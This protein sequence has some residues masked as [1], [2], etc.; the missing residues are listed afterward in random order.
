MRIDSAGEKT[1]LVSAGRVMPRPGN[2]RSQRA[3][4]NST[5][6]STVKTRTAWS[7]TTLLSPQFQ[8]CWSA[9]SWSVTRLILSFNTCCSLAGISTQK[10]PAKPAIEQ[11]SIGCGVSLLRTLSPDRNRQIHFLVRCGGFGFGF[12]LL[13]L[14]LDSGGWD[15]L[16]GLGDGLLPVGEEAL[17]VGGLGEGDVLL[18]Q[19]SHFGQV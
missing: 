11:V 8:S 4:R 13:A 12:L 6:V 5:F 9:A 3:A 7:L 2:W 17:G 18:D 10:L 16:P 14:E 15:D 1:S 19:I